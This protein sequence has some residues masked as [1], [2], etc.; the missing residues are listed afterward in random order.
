MKDLN[1]NLNL[2]MIKILNN[3]NMNNIEYED[4]LLNHFIPVLYI[5][6]QELTSPMSIED[7]IYN[8]ELCIGGT[9]KKIQKNIFCKPTIIRENKEIIIEKNEIKLPLQNKYNII[10]NKYLNYCGKDYFP[11]PSI[12]NLVPVYGIIKY[13]KDYIDIIYIF[14]YYYNNP[15]KFFGIYVG[16]E[17]QADLEHIRIRITNDNF[18]NNNLPYKVNSIYYSAH[19]TDQGRW[20]KLKNIEWYNN[21]PNG[22]PVIYVAKGSHANY[23]KPGTWFRIFGFANDKTTKKKAI[24]WMPYT[25]INLNHNTDIMSYQGDMGNDGVNSINRDWGDSPPE[26]T[27]STLLYRFF[28]PLSK[29]IKSCLNRNK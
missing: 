23:P 16:G 21:I 27:Y 5:H 7:Y 1:K 15:Y 19:S 22:Q 26:D 24:K 9:K 14:N 11:N 17:H 4:K 3:K 8:C 6:P 2:I 10:P 28:Y 25:V 13:Y 12:I 18:Y 29:I 20:E